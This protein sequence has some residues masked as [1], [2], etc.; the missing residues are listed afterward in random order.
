MQVAWGMPNEVLTKAIDALAA[1]RDLSADEAAEVLAQ[2]MY[3]EVTETQIAGFLIALRTKG[4]TTELAGLARTMRA[5]RRMSRRARGPAR[6]AF[7]GGGQRTFNV[8]T[9]AALIAA[10]AGLPSP[11]TATAPLPAPPA[12]RTCSRRWGPASTSIRRRGRFIE[13]AG[14]GFMFAPAHHQATRL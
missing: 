12:P 14:F 3:G 8:S 7:T 10:G 11:S 1:R 13:E 2:I 9:T 5:W 6:Q 4:E